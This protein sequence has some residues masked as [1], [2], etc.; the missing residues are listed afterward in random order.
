MTS[1]VPWADV[2]ASVK[3]RRIAAANTPPVLNEDPVLKGVR[4][5]LVH[6]SVK[7]ISNR[8]LLASL[9]GKMTRALHNGGRTRIQYTM[10]QALVHISKDGAT[11]I[12]C[13]ETECPD[14]RM[15][16]AQ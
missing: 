11:L 15:Y 14:R 13:E 6:Q 5:A 8:F 9:A 16:A 7:Q 10:N 2:Q 1:S 3:A 4:S 12:K